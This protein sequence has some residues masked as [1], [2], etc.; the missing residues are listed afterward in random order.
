MIGRRAGIALALVA[1]VALATSVHAGPVRLQP[2]RGH[3]SVGYS[4]L[5]SDS[6]AP[7][8]SFSLAVGLDYPVGARVRVGPTVGYHL[9]GSNTVERGS[10]SATV[11]YSLLEGAMLVSWLPARGPVA[12]LSAGPAV[13]SAHAELSTA[14]GGLGFR[15]LAVGEV[16]GGLALETT[17]LSR[18]QTVV[19]PGFEAGLRWFPVSGHDWIVVTA[20][21]TVHY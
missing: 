11:D 6:L 10:L 3:L 12:R 1:L 5:F 7:G 21:A 4:K 13:G 2:W 17:F 8:G 16:K 15:D 18:R 14:G 9:L 20:R 19:A